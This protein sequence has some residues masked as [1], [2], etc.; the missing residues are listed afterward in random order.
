MLMFRSTHED[1]VRGLRACHAEENKQLNRQ[2]ESLYKEILRL[3]EIIGT[4]GTPVPVTLEATEDEHEAVR[5]YFRRKGLKVTEFCKTHWGIGSGNNV[6]ADYW[7]TKD[8]WRIRATKAKT[9]HGALHLVNAINNKA[10][11]F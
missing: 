7:P 11:Y 4:V 9:L 2:I 10:Q 8:K 1:F 5:N 3:N 6:V